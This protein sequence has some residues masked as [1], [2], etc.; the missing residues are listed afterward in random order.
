MTNQTPNRDF[1]R[2]HFRA[3]RAYLIGGALCGAMT[4]SMALAQ[5]AAPQPVESAEAGLGEIVVT[6]QKRSENVQRVP[7]AIT[8]VDSKMLA[9]RQIKS[10]LD[11]S[12]NLPAFKV[13]MSSPA[14]RIFLRGIGS[15]GNGSFEQSVGTF[16]DGIYFGRAKSTESNFFDIE[17][18][19]LLKGPQSTYFGNSAIAGVL[20]ITTKMPGKVAE[21]FARALYEPTDGGYAFEAGATIPLNA[22]FAVRVSGQVSGSNGWMFDEGYG[23]KVGGDDNKAGRVILSYDPGTNFKA[24]IKGEIGKEHN[25]GAIIGEG[26]RCPPPA[27]FVLNPT[28]FCGIALANGFTNYKLDNRRATTPG[29]FLNMTRQLVTAN[30][31]LDLGGVTV[32]SVTGFQHHNYQI[33]FDID[34]SPVDLLSA[35]GPEKFSQFSQEL[36][37]AS[38]TGGTIEYI[39]GLYYQHSVLDQSTNIAFSFLALPPALASLAPFGDSFQFHER[40]DSYSA[41]GALTWN[42]SPDLKVTG[43]LRGTK[44]VKHDTQDVYFGRANLPDGIVRVTGPLA[45]TVNAVFGPALGV[46]PGFR[47]VKGKYSHLMPSV[48]AQYQ[49]TPTAMAYAK[50]ANGF[51]AGGF[52]GFDA[53]GVNLPFKPETVNAFEVGLKSKLFDGHVLFNFDLFYSKYKNLQQVTTQFSGNSILN[54]I[55]NVDGAVSKGIEVEGRWVIDEHWEMGGTFSYLQA[56]YGSYPN[57]SPRPIDTLN[58]IRIRD[59]S[60]LRTAYSPKYSGAGDIQFHTPVGENLEFRARGSIYYS[61]DYVITDTLDPV[62]TQHDY[63]KLDAVIALSNPVAGWEL[64]VIGKNLTNKQPFIWGADTPLTAGSYTVS[65]E[66]PRQVAFQLRYSW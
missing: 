16:V 60:G 19:E 9:D 49:I 34:N 66:K 45:A 4:S 55:R 24:W 57:G 20:N 27:P 65:R 40:A 5:E 30:M 25:E 7:V 48:N 14:N 23:H 21:G 8:V 10:L 58:G 17:R 33:F 50:Y 42:I 1:R 46:N 12:G 61:T 62:L 54:I 36:R 15:G 51:K 52:N 3:L 35:T 32:T 6:A 22:A 59:Y 28:S 53:T 43:G 11:L 31:Q 38:E 37:F 41:F 39:G 18:I 56:H 29:K 64:S 47:R 26:I 63:A 44:V 13:S 2:R